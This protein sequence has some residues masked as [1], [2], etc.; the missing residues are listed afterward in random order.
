VTDRPRALAVLITVFL[1]GCII[2]SAGFYYWFEKKPNIPVANGRNGLPPGPPRQSLPELLQLTP[3]QEKRYREI[4]S[5]AHKQHES[6]RREQEEMWDKLRA[7]QAPKIKEIWAETNRKFSA[8]L[9]EEQ[10]ER[11]DAFLKEMEAM[12]KRPPRGRGFEPKR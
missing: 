4:M 2:G 6:L 10:K 9:N 1:L 5:E 12:R 3:D 11:F 8:I 7:E